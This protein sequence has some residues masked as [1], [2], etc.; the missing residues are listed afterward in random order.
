M[1][2]GL[3][4]D[5]YVP[6][7]N[8][9]A[10]STHILRCEL[11]KRGHT[12]YVVTTRSGGGSSEWDEDHKVLRLPGIEL[13][14]LYGYVMTAPFHIHAMN[15]VKALGL[16]IIHCQTEFG[17]GIF[18]RLASRQLSVPLV[19]TY[20]TTYE[21]YTHYVNLIN[22]KMVD[23]VA[24]R[25]VVTFSRMSG[26]T[27]LAVIAP[28]EKTKQ[29]LES[30]QVSSRI[31]VIPTGLMLEKFSPALRDDARTAQ[32]RSEAGFLPEDKVIIYVGRLA[33]EK[34]LDIVIR[35]FAHA[36]QEGCRSKLLIIGGGPDE[37]KLK[38]LVKQTGT[39]GTVFLAGRR[40]ADEVPDYY[41]AAD[42]FISASLS[43]TQGMTFI[44]ALSSGLPLF[45]RRDEVLDDLLVPEKTGWF[46]ADEA[47]LARKLKEFEALPEETLA[48][49]KEECLRTA[50]PCS[51][52]IFCAKV[53]QVYEYA[54]G[55][56]LHMSVIEDAEVR[57]D[58]VQL[59]LRS[60]KNEET[61]L[62]IT[63]DDY[64][65]E[66]LRRGA[67]ITDTEIARLRRRET[68]AR[69]YQRCIRRLAFRDRTRKEI[70]DWLEKE[71]EC[72]AEMIRRIAERLEEKGYLNDERYA[73]ES[74]L[75]MRLALHGEKKIRSELARRGIAEDII[76]EKLHSVPDEEEESALRYARKS[77]SGVRDDSLR[78]KKQ[79][80]RSKLSQRGFSSDI[81]DDVISRIT[82]DLD[83]SGETDNLRRCAEKARRRYEKKYASTKLRNAVY[84]YCASQG[85]EA[86][87][88]Y[89]VLDEM[90]WTND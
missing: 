54:I 68:A 72:D 78:R 56:Y 42:A 32:I 83:A 28:S 31:F 66:G 22:S 14:K 90:E 70:C 88:I 74:I 58:F 4:S 46:F 51:S 29:L 69:A 45:A 76:E 3:F 33:E 62:L 18:A 75:R 23:E 19:S 47:D 59:Y 6:E 77:L 52:E 5:T 84:R 50:A 11:E 25:A 13:K 17:V 43:E 73:Q 48:A 12:V 40:M 89:A 9:V 26:D 65:A 53:L 27:A 8:G 55:Q 24:R 30:Y 39:E 21:D 79:K 61:T 37:E 87:E 10:N 64:L 81:I 86:G 41:R 85:Y 16:D 60:E 35:G 80:I 57:D 71:T 63:L 67:R 82:D 34:A 49:M 44:E 15:E 36:K 20:H 2:I 38:E 7:I 1:V